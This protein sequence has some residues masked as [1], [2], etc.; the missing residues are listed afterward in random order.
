MIEGIDHIIKRLESLKQDLPEMVGELIEENAAMVEDLQT[1]QLEAGI[2]SEGEK[3]TPAYSVN[4]VAIKKAKGQPH[5]RVT[6]KDTGAFHR[7][8]FLSGGQAGQFSVGNSDPK[9]AKLEDKYGPEIFGLTDGS[10]QELI[11]GLLRAELPE[12]VRHKLLN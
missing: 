1:A 7:A 4:T 5:D 6:L 3:I 9:A 11:D 12:R 10:K 2:D 8:M